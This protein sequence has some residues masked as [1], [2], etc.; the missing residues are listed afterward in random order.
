MLNK[1]VVEFVGTLLLVFVIARTGN[2]LAIGATLALIHMV[3]VSVS[4]GM[5]N[6]AVT[7]AMSI[8]GRVPR[9]EFLLH[10]LAQCAGGVTALEVLR[11]L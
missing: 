7:L 6:P 8:A 10:V 3:G 1:Y 2:S 11:R 5:F 9:N 4:G